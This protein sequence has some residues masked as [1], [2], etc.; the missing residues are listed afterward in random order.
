MKGEITVRIE[1]YMRRYPVERI[2]AT[3][4]FEQ[5]RVIGRNGSIVFQSNRPLLRSNGLRMK[6]I[7]WKLIEGTLRSM[8]A[9]DAL[10]NSLDEYVKRLEKEGKL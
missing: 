5:F 6:R 9:K 3:P 10:A 2:N 7:E 1:G 8:S 4:R